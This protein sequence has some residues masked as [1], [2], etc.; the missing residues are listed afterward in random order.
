MIAFTDY[1]KIVNNYCVCY[2]GQ[3]DEYLI[4][5]RIL[6]PVLE[7]AFPD[8]T[9]YIGCKD[10]KTD[11]ISEC[12]HVLSI[13]EL[14]LRKKEFAHISEIKY[15]GSTH[16]IEDFIISSGITNFG[17][18]PTVPDKTTKCVI[19]TKSS[20]PTKPLEKI[21]IEKLKRIAVMQGMLC[22]FDTDI[23]GAGLVMGVE[24]AGLCEA[25]FMGIE[26]CLMPTGVGTRLYKN[27]FP[28]MK[29]VDL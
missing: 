4:Q 29:I 26:T 6:K 28:K 22:E 25:A 1:A 23:T 12:E 20:H 10:D 17:I 8:L 2:F 3:S 15:N 21:K 27:M 11:F 9:I 18:K 16:P 5:L 13:T 19:I 24:S 7:I 14:K